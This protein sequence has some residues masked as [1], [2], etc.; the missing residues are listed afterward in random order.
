M[1]RVILL[2]AAAVLALMAADATAKPGE[3]LKDVKLTPASTAAR[4]AAPARPAEDVAR[5]AARKP[6]EM[7]AFAEVKP[8]QKVVDLIP[9]GGYFTRVFSI[10][11]G[12]GGT[13]Y[14]AAPPAN[15]PDAQPAAA[16]IAAEPGYGDVKVLSIP[17]GGLQPPEPVDAIFTAQ[18]YHDLHLKRLNLDVAAVDKSFFNALKPGG[19]LVVV[20]HAAA[21]G[22]PI[23]TAD[24][25]HRIDPAIVK[26][27]LEAAG[28][29]LEAESDVLRN[30]ADPKT[31]NVFDP[32]IRGKT[33]Q[34]VM[35]F[36]KP[37]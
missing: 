35:R 9:G 37:K 33:D 22:A 27:E 36:R 19:V 3:H 4:A 8:G 24:T 26:R 13:V 34:F 14:A 32:A 20:D 17:A 5:D 12:E 21:A 25:L 6:R 2:A 16:K 29:A 7:V 15:S 31:A 30:P 10:A 1:A 11:V 23:E 28:F 18:N